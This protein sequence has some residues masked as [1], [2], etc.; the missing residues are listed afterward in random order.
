MNLTC[1]SYTDTARSQWRG[2]HVL[3]LLLSRR[4]HSVCDASECFGLYR[5]RTGDHADAHEYL[6]ALLSAM[7]D[8]AAKSMQ[9]GSKGGTSPRS[10]V[11]CIFGG[12]HQSQV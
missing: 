6:Y 1:H 3:P 2:L 10:L 12:T 9:P 5:Y 7:N 11:H 4:Y 8:A